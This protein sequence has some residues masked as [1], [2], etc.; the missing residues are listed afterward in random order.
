MLQICG[1]FYVVK[2]LGWTRTHT[3]TMVK[4]PTSFS[5]FQIIDNIPCLNNV[6]KIIPM[7]QKFHANIPIMNKGNGMEQ[8]TTFLE[9]TRNN[10]LP[11]LS[12]VGC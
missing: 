4:I 7:S 3:N 12:H 11:S 2:G 1:L 10:L 8:Y 5:F 9:H 6:P